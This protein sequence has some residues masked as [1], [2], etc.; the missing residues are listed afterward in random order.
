MYIDSGLVNGTQYFYYV[1]AVGAGNVEIGQSNVDSDTPDS[2]A[3]PW[4]SQNASQIISTITASASQAI[5]PDPEDPEGSPG[6]VGT[7]VAV[8][9]DG[10]VYMGNF[11]DGSP[12][13]VTPP[14]GYYDA[15]TNSMLNS[16]GTTTAISPNVKRRINSSRLSPMV[17]VGDTQYPAFPPT[18]IVRQVGSQPGMN[19]FTGV[20]GLPNAADSTQV[21]LNV[22]HTGHINPATG[23]EYVYPDS[24]GIYS[25]GHI[26]YPASVV[27]AHPALNNSYDNI[28]VGFQL[29]NYPTPNT[30]WQPFIMPKLHRSVYVGWSNT[31]V[32]AGYWKTYVSG[33]VRFQFLTPVN[34]NVRT[35]TI[36]VHYEQPANGFNTTILV[37]RV[38][39]TDSSGNPLFDKTLNV[40]GITIV[41][42]GSGT[43]HWLSKPY[44]PSH[45]EAGNNDFV[46][47]RANVIAQTVN[48]VGQS[49]IPFAPTADGPGGGFKMDGSFV[50]GGYWGDSDANGID[51]ITNTHQVLSWTNDSS[52]TSIAGSYPDSRFV[53]WTEQNPYFWETNINMRTSLSTLPF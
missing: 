27:S 38:S 28:D 29:T 11:P 32:L 30:M 10:L 31:K 37:K 1:A 39:G 13:I 17:A 16:D 48:P 15:T 6:T 33:E 53:K 25:G 20:L 52:L 18:G 24:A 21:N 3:T 14:T 41:Y 35:K 34:S 50:Y 4:D 26:N 42:S 44:D 9:P 22:Y 45:P 12:A 7:V 2:A 51:L 49:I 46:L 43:R 40:S 36:L 19:A 47:K 23:S 8:S 5:L